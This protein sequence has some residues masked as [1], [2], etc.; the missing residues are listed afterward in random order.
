MKLR[1]QTTGTQATNEPL[2][3]KKVNISHLGKRK[4]IDSKMPFLGN[5]LV[6]WRVYLFSLFP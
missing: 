6:P 4:I 2:A 1:I 3:D 5:M